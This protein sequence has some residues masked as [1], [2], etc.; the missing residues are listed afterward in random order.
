MN[1]AP[2]ASALRLS[3]MTGLPSASEIDGLLFRQ[4]QEE[5]C[6]D[7][8]GTGVHAVADTQKRGG[9]C[10]RE[11]GTWRKRKNADEVKIGLGKQPSP[12]EDGQ[13]TALPKESSGPASPRAGLPLN[14]AAVGAKRSTDFLPAGATQMEP[15]A[16]HNA[17]LGIQAP[18]EASETGTTN[19]GHDDKNE[20]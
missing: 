13:D 6:Y 9:R 10:V 18:S 15:D 11:I 4:Q 2:P 5:D 17:S 20:N 16:Y 1:P 19:M 12:G 3:M 14:G 8:R 7:I